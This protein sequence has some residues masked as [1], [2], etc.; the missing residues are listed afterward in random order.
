MNN[1]PQ[2]TWDDL[3][4]FLA[5]ARTGQLST[6]ARQLR[7]SHAVVAAGLGAAFLP[8]H[9]VE[10]LGDRTHQKPLSGSASKWAVGICW[11]SADSNPL[12]LRFIDYVSKHRRA[13]TSSRPLAHHDELPRA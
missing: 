10:A 5:V 2:F 1:P 9:G 7:S 12:L 6:A 13:P 8:W 11:R 3:Q 4:F